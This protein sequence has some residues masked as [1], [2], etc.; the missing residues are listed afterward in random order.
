MG[1]LTVGLVALSVGGCALH[2]RA[3]APDLD[4]RARIAPSTETSDLL[5]NLRL[6]FDQLTRLVEQVAIPDRKLGQTSALAGWSLLI[7][8]RPGVR[9]RGDGERLCFDVPFLGQGAVQMLGREMRRA[10]SGRIEVCARPRLNPDAVLS[11]RDPAIRVEVE[12]GRMALN[13]RVLVD[14]LR[15][16][17]GGD[18]TRALTDALTELRLPLRPLLRPLTAA[19]AGS[20]RLGDG[21]CL[22]PRAESVVLG[23]P[24]ITSEGLRF[25]AALRGHPTLEAPCSPDSQPDRPPLVEATLRIEQRASRLLIPVGLST[26]RARKALLAELRRRGPI[27]WPGGHVSV[28]DLRI[29][30]SRG[31]VVV[32]AMLDGRARASFLGI[33]TTRAIDGEVILW[34]RPTLHEGRVGLA[35]VQLSIVLDDAVADLAAAL[36]ASDLRKLVVRHLSLPVAQVETQARAQLQQL[37]TSL[38]I[39]AVAVPARVRIERL[40]VSGA[41]ASAQRLILETRFV[42]WIV[43]APPALNKSHKRSGPPRP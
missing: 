4:V 31:A 15:A 41:R 21:A 42:G 29:D 33:S 10:V 37:A 24:Q 6:G 26:D 18:A 22:R 40:T 2:A 1:L 5:L 14:Q 28:K 20:L 11:L 35:Q 17:L 25:A 12:R 19:L 43:L 30:T 38:K 16:F 27:T 23:Q 39:G 8:K 13:S 3:P 32:H 9:V 34:G 7:Q 36:R